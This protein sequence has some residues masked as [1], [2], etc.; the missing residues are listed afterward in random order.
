MSLLAFGK[1]LCSKL[2]EIQQVL[3]WVRETFEL[4]TLSM[5]GVTI[6]TLED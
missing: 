6:V 2:L 4:S 5:K 3:G 1:T